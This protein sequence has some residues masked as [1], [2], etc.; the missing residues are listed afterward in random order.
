MTLSAS[1][2][3]ALEAQPVIVAH[4]AQDGFAARA[5]ARSAVLCDALEALKQLLLTI[6]LTRGLARAVHLLSLIHI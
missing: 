4:H 3:R 1:P 5:R 2:H 6:N